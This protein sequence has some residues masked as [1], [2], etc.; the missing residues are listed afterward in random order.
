MTALLQG[1]IKAGQVNFDQD[2]PIVAHLNG[3]P[4]TDK[5]G[6][7]ISAGPV[8]HYHQGIPFDA[9]GRMCMIAGSVNYWG[10]GA[11]PFNTGPEVAFGSVL[12]HYSSGVPYTPGGALI[13]GA[14]PPNVLP[15][16]TWFNARGSVSGGDFVPPEGWGTGFWPPDDAIASNRG[17]YNAIR[18]IALNSQNRGYLEYTLGTPFPVGT[19]INVSV[20]VEE[21]IVGTGAQRVIHFNTQGGTNP[22]EI[23][24]V[25][26]IVPGFVG[27]VDAVYEILDDQN[28]LQV[29]VGTGTTA[30]DNHD[31]TLSRPQ[32]T[33]GEVGWPWQPSPRPPAGF[34]YALEIGVR[35]TGELYGFA[36]ETSGPEVFGDCAPRTWGRSTTDRIH[37]FTCN[38]NNLAI[39]ESLNTAQWEGAD[40]LEIDIEGFRTITVSWD[41]TLND[42][43]SGVA[44]LYD[45]FEANNGEV[46]GFSVSPPPIFQ[47]TF[48]GAANTDLV[49]HD[50]DIGGGYTALGGVIQLD[51]NGGCTPAGTSPGSGPPNFWSRLTDV[52]SATPKFIRWRATDFGDGT[53]LASGVTVLTAADGSAKVT[54]GLRSNGLYFQTFQAGAIDDTEFL[55]DVGRPGDG[56]QY[57][58]P[59]YAIVDG[60]TVT[61]GYG[62]PNAPVFEATRD[63]SGLTGLGDGI[64]LI[65]RASGVNVISDF[66][67]YEW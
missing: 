64:G 55:E 14:V 63:F 13:A 42:Y 22:R 33:L 48:E 11:A 43:R 57:L 66:A 17:D 3:F 37:R 59:F 36:T 10:G 19:I 65:G 6:I 24:Q 30:N 47:D 12:D 26:P 61:Y 50:P 58:L 38:Q 60:T 51:G 45:F 15:N 49:D 4:Y 46:I 20:Y 54:C 53:S 35:S 5:G 32:I 21:C 40:E 7:A 39:F 9:N 8:D 56:N 34:N 28:P 2:G 67:C 16:N 44:G 41:N 62:D 25:R 18:F 27:R 1:K 23:R 29:R 52:T 31:Y